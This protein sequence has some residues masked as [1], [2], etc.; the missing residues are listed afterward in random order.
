MAAAVLLVSL[1]GVS[2]AHAKDV[3]GDANPNYCGVSYPVGR[4]E[5]IRNH[6][7]RIIGYSQ[8]RWS[9]GCGG[10]NFVRAWTADGKANTI[11]S[12]L[13]NTS[14]PVDNR[15]WAGS[16][17]WANRHYTMGIRVAPTQKVCAY[18]NLNW[19]YDGSTGSYC[20]T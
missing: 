12:A 1:L 13:W 8:I 6:K 14:T 20:R 2:P 17:D 5:V 3:G 10:I 18:T 11:K 9:Y 16:D 19:G 7:N 4:T 15:Q